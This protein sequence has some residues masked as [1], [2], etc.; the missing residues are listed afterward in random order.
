[1]GANNCPVGRNGLMTS[2][3]LVATFTLWQNRRWGKRKKNYLKCSALLTSYWSPRVSTPLTRACMAVTMFLRTSSLASSLSRPVKPS[4]WRSFICL[5]KVDFPASPV[6]SSNSFISFWKHKKHCN[7]KIWKSIG[8]LFPPH[9]IETKHVSFL[10]FYLVP[11][12]VYEIRFLLLFFHSKSRNET[13]V[14]ACFLSL[15]ICLSISLLIFLSLFL[16]SSLTQNV[17]V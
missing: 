13:L 8:S 2:S 14:L 16:F 9:N 17:I 15:F 12:I 11:S 4:P 5:T 1:M 3:L 7:S 10:L 6:P